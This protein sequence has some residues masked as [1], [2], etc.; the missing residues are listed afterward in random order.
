MTKESETM[1]RNVASN[2][3]RYFVYTALKGFGFGLFLA[4]WVIYLQQQRGLS[5]SQAALIDVTFFVAAALAE[6]PTGIVA[7]RFGRKTSMTAGATL[8]CAGLLGWTFAPTLPLIIIAYVAMG[9]GI[10]FL[11]G[12]E[13]AFFYE[14]LR[15]SGR[16]DDYARLL[17][18][19]SATFPGALALGSVLSG[20][21]AAINLILPFL[22]AG[23][24]LLLALG[25]VLT[26]KEPQAEKGPRG[27]A[28]TSL[29]EVLRQSLALMR[30]RPALRFSILY[31]AIVPLASFMIESVFVQPQAL[32]LG[33]PLAGIGII[34]MAVQFTA[35]VGSAWSGRVTARF[36]EERVLYTAP[37]VIC[38]SLLLLAAL[39]VLPALLFIAVMGFLT[40]VVRPI[41]V[42]RMQDELSDDVRATMLSMQSL[43]FTIVAAMSQ[44]TLGAI[45]DQWGLPAAYVALAGTLSGVM[46]FVFW[47]SRRHVPQPGMATC[48]SQLEPLEPIAE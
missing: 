8:M 10:T 41:L 3:P 9:V 43:T 32:A 35:M 13:D 17:G 21:L 24:V 26:F 11:S 47:K 25:V 42:S 27:Q 1:K 40:A 22:V 31:L 7:D 46:V 4:V 20:F 5:L 18:R 6:L 34:I 2:I 28:R 38:S 37:M 33:V 29:R 23:L 36:G 16:G 30:A 45:A 48:A 44:P 39:Q 19:V 15:E 12:A 14:T